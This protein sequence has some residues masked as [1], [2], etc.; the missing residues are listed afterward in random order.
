MS[1]IKRAAAWLRMNPFRNYMVSIAL[2]LLPVSVFI[3]AAHKLLLRQVTS[4][5]IAQST[6]QGGLVGGI[7]VRH[8]DECR[9]IL[10]SFSTRPSLVQQVEEKKFDEVTKHLE[11]LL[12]LQ[13]D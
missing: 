7:L 6:Q 13:P 9:I 3:F 5:V 12:K 11:Q 8:L 4:T 2:A 10:E 1:I